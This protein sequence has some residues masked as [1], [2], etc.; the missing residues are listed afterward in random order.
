M[1]KENAWKPIL[2]TWIL[3]LIF[4]GSLKNKNKKQNVKK[5][6]Y[7]YWKRFEKNEYE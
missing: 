3:C 4:L 2:E 1:K 5:I 7:N 6:L